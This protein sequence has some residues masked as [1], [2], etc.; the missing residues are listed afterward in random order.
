MKKINALFS[1]LI[2]LGLMLS[3]YQC[4]SAEMS[5]AKLYIQQKNWDKATESLNKEIS[6]N[7]K[8]D[9]AFYLLGVVS[10]EKEDLKGMVENFNKSLE[11]SSKFKK[12]IDV[13][14]QNSWAEAFNGGVSNYNK[15]AQSK[16]KDTTAMF[17]DK[18]L[19][20]FNT[21][22]FL[23]P[24][25]L[26]SYKIVSMIYLTRGENDKAIP[27]LEKIIE[28]KGS[29][30][31]YAQLAEIYIKKG[32]VKNNSYK[33]S[34]NAADSVAAQSDFNKALDIAKKGLNVHPGNEN[35]LQSL[36]SIYGFLNQAEEGA[37]LFEGEVKK[38]PNNKLSRL[39]FGIF[40]TNIQNYT[41]AVAEF[42]E[43][44][45]LDPNFFEAYY[46]E[47][48]AY[49]NWGL[50][51]LKKADANKVDGRPEA[52]PKFEK[53]VENAKIYVEKAPKEK[54][55]YDLLFKAYTRLSKTKEAE[56]VQK[57]LL[58]MK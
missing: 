19:D 55:G 36:A 8:S 3:G 13:I 25:S 11:I 39:Y 47:G 40:L 49:Y 2:L 56:E 45:K 14:T 5:S 30:Y 17:L 27:I 54:K 28:K 41:G 24:D 43:V 46:Y 48:F 51:I 32:E 33:A 29:D 12:E 21:A 50:T 42:A 23:E 53:C 37:A 1:G 9:E 58:E 26:E 6:K 16:S 35:L 7:P 52:N 10:K 34:K 31:A 20:K 15:A 44:I 57:I 38:N 22:I 4:S 18:A